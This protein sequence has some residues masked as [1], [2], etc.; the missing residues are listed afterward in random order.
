[1]RVDLCSK[2]LAFIAWIVHRQAVLTSSGG[3]A[4]MCT[5]ASAEQAA[6]EPRHLA[7]AVA[8]ESQFDHRVLTDRRVDIIIQCV[9]RA[10]CSRCT[11]N[12]H[13]REAA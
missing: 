4:L 1:M 13:R 12:T 11:D 8:V 2:S 6:D 10:V 3:G 9:A 7:I 5:R